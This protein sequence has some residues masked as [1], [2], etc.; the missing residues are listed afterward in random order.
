MTARALFA[1]ALGVVLLRAPSA[2]AQQ[3]V[4]WTNVVNA[5]TMGSS[6]QK[7]SG[8]DGCEDAGGVTLERIA[9]GP[10]SFQFVPGVGREI[11]VGLTQTTVTPLFYT[12]FDYAFAI[13]PDSRCEIREFGI[14]RAD[15]AFTAGDVLKI[16][17]EPG[18]IA[19]YYRNG[20]LLYASS[21]A[22][23]NYP[24]VLGADL[25]N[26]GATIVEAQITAGALPVP[27]KYR[28]TTSRSVHTKPPLPQ[29][30]AAGTRFRDPTFGSSILRVTDGNTRPGSPG[31]SFTA[32][33]AAHQLAWNAT[34]DR[35]YVRSI[36]GE[37]IP[38]SFDASTMTA[39]RI[40]PSATGDGGLVISSQVEPQFSFISPNLLYGSRQ[41]PFNNWP[42]VQR[43][44]FTTLTYADVLN[45][46]AVTTL[47]SGTYAGAL[48]SSAAA[49][50]KLCI[51]FG[52]SAQDS[53]FKVAVL[54]ASGAS[55]VV[56]D[57]LASTVTVDG[58]ASNTNIPLGV[59]LHHAWMD[60]SG[61]YVILYTV[62][63]QPVPYF[64]WDVD[65]GTVSPVDRNATG[66]DATGF[67]WQ[68]NQGCC[69]TTT[70][71]A[72]QW[73]LRALSAP[74]NTSDIIDPVLTPEEIY[75][76]DH[77]SWNNAQAGTL[78]P[79]LSS[80]YRY[81]NGTY[82]TTPWRA[83]DDE[84]VALQTGQ[85]GSG[86]AVWRFAHHRSDVTYDGDPTR[87]LYFWYVP[88]AVISPNGRWAIFT[89]N[90]EKTL[91]LAVGSDIQPGGNYRCD[92]FLVALR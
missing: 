80:L 92:V 89:S 70:Y 54:Q 20:G 67:R 81:F 42:I 28:A 86:G 13:Y 37:F 31:R 23:V 1:V 84:I 57:S 4:T 82:N 52:G 44:D 69:T 29:V 14:W 39:A 90:W 18:P 3:N 5:T 76:A 61:R 2:T 45:L 91:G 75:L 41:D 27:V 59:Y 34:S 46:G 53:H 51:L 15:C 68:I 58:V 66:H 73:E 40:A 16:A 17:I 49:P 47:S 9:R 30:G 12:A 21:I 26:A 11:Y 38:Y 62:N 63:Q 79:I 60:Q 6:L 7:T 72:A 10:G 88:N 8:C 43:F 33:S 65:T 19:K 64:V 22:P 78:V 32:P 56:L 85:L 35:F 48:S 77:T 25:F 55:P 71:D 36:D 24:F 83:W 74:A 87:A 50:E